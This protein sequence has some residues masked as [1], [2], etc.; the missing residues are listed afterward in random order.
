VEDLYHYRFWGQVA[1][2]MS[3]QRNM[4][5]G[6][7]V[8]VFFNPERPQPG[9]TV[10]L[11]ANA[12]EPDGS[13]LRDGGVSVDLT[14]PDGRSQRLSLEKLESTWGSFSG[15]FKVDQPGTWKLRVTNHNDESNP[16]E[17]SLIAQGSEIE[18]TGQPARPEVL[19]EITRI[20]RGRII[21]PDQIPSLINE[22]NALPQ[23][24]PIISRTPLWSHW[25]T[26]TALISLL[27]TFW[28]ARKLSGQF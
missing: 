5:A 4:A 7:R 27:A 10:T 28:T 26:L 24:H 12:F 17:T 20:T 23:P 25:A 14:S 9:D 21:Q 11:N 16:L 6:K 1:R 15:R 8:R 19:E 13:P 3:Y 2:W 18:K 22:I